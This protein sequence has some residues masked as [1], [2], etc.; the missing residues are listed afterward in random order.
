MTV[1]G[2]V[3]LAAR[4]ALAAAVVALTTG[5]W[6]A[7]PLPAH[8]RSA[9]LPSGAGIT[10][11]DREGVVLRTTR[12]ADGS[13]VRWMPLDAIDPDIIA[14]F[15]A[16][17]DQRFY[18]HHGIDWHG[19]A[20][21][22][23]DN[24]F[25]GRV[26]SGASTI[27]MQ[28]ARQVLPL[29]RGWFGKARQALWALRLEAHLSKQEILE[30]Y[31]NRVE[32][33]QGALGV[34]AAAALYFDADVGEL[35]LAQAA[36]LAG[37]AHAP[38]RGS[39]LVSPASATQRR[40]FALTRLKASGYA[41]PAEVQRARGEPLVAA[42]S[43]A[44]FLAPHFTSRMLS[45][46]E[47]QPGCAAADDTPSAVDAEFAL[48][49]GDCLRAGLV[50][51]TLDLTLQSEIESE[52]RATMLTLRDRGVAHAAVVVIENSTG[53]VRAWVGSPDFWADTA[54]Q[55]DMV[56]SARQPGSSLKPFLYGLAFDRGV[57]PATVLA[58]VQHSYATPAGPYRPRNY[59]RRYHGPVR[60]REA[61]ASSYNVPAVDLVAQIGPAA[62]LRTL[63]SAGF[64][65]LT[66]SGDY[67][68]LGLA[69][70]DGDV[71]LLELANGYRSLVNAGEWKPL[72]FTG[73][74]PSPSSITGTRVMSARSAALV[75]DILSDPV[76]RAPGFG[77]ETPFDFPFRA[78][79]KTG[80]SR[81]FTDNWSVGVTAGFTVAV[82]VGN[83][84]GRPM[85]GVSGV[86]G[87]GPLLAHAM[88]LTAKRIPA[89]DLVRPETV[90]A[91]A[92][93]ICRVSGMRAGATCP[94]VTEW[95]APGT[96][97]AQ[98]CN[99][100]RS[101]AVTLPAEYAEWQAQQRA[102]LSSSLAAANVRVGDPVGG[103]DTVAANTSFR[104]VSPRN[105]DRYQIP[106][107]VPARYATVALL[108]SGGESGR[109]IAWYVDGRR[110]KASR[111][112]LAPGA[113][114]IRAVAD[115]RH[116]EVR[117]VVE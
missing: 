80:T 50:K 18:R 55:T 90:G 60:A 101:G 100:H 107:G 45:V 61:L 88:L 4:A 8:V 39:P 5:A 85:Q 52:I 110:T 14:A 46:L 69:L 22:A 82:W 104:I 65:S 103:H 49:A 115:R 91:H 71:T 34:G 30:R 105:G 66:R 112:A 19:V 58:D 28:L 35:S 76:A 106:P 81:H 72:R 15:V 13:R 53:A 87:A 83:F 70:G 114:V 98:D 21:A 54:G 47:G 2:A 3:A 111:L 42:R 41:S 31:L 10:L 92:V 108:V 116:D 51:T 16:V 36:L 1:R 9:E 38:S 113:H 40:A 25:E 99:W 24:L 32:M 17:E 86:A 23:W 63:R 7:W 33:G 48:P 109:A 64:S 43:V 95:F 117:V 97:P 78:A 73:D 56:A 89:G 12:A 102:P 26:V 44:P 68:G 67:Y 57:T 96:E 27:T 29:N 20:R 77:I 11:T 94:H 74:D 59:D 6:I 93:E 62:L 79:V 84:N 37:I 75:L